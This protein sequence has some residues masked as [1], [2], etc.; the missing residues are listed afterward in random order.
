VVSNVTLAYYQV[1][2]LL[3][4]FS[5]APTESLDQLLLACLERSKSEQ[6][7]FVILLAHLLRSGRQPASQAQALGIR[8][9]YEHP[10]SEQEFDINKRIISTFASYSQDVAWWAVSWKL[11]TSDK[12]FAETVFD[13]IAE[14]HHSPYL[15]RLAEYELYNLYLLAAE[16]FV[17]SDDIDFRGGT[18]PPRHTQQQW[19]DG[20][21]KELAGRGTL[22]SV[23]VLTECN[24]SGGIATNG[25]MG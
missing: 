2:T 15:Q 8:R 6:E 16:L 19:R 22:K 1:E 4:R 14:R 5:T 24:C 12:A 9:L 11:L 3:R 17:Y 13:A 20:I 10:A 25:K 23:S 21:L 18:V 7:L